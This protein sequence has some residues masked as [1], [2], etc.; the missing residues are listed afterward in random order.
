[1]LR[2]ETAV[3]MNRMGSIEN[4]KIESP[5]LPFPPLALKPQITIGLKAQLI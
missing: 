4:R 2:T 3:L 1:M 5:F